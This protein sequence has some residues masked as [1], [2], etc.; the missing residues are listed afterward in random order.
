MFGRRP[1]S[2]MSYGGTQRLFQILHS[3]PLARIIRELVR[4]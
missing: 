1:L 3:K 2:G 4:E